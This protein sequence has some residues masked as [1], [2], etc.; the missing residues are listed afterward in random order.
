M[1]MRMLESMIKL[2]VK[3]WTRE[4]VHHQAARPLPEMQIGLTKHAA[5][6]TTSEMKRLEIKRMCYVESDPMD[7]R[8]DSLLERHAK[9]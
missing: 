6:M 9:K 3:L 8:H 5:R 2:P 7:F 4:L 1:R